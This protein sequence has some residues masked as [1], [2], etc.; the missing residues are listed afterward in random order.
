MPGLA[1][2]PAARSG[3]SDVDGQNGYCIYPES[4][5]VRLKIIKRARRRRKE[6]TKPE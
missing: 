3:I 1:G 6:E 5:V 4:C 2:V